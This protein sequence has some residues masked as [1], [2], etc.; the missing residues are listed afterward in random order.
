MYVFLKVQESLSP[1]IPEP[2]VLKERKRESTEK[3]E[4]ES[5]EI[6][7]KGRKEGNRFR[8]LWQVKDILCTVFKNISS[9]V[10][11]VRIA[12]KIFSSCCASLNL[13]QTSLF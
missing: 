12:T 8:Q 9:I 11:F 4:R 7:G 13:T 3:E 5:K 10:L 6:K 2:E 1:E